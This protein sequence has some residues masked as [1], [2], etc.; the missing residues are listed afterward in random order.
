M[1][2]DR[3]DPWDF[4][5]WEPPP[6]G[7][8]DRDSWDEDDWEAHLARQD[9]LS[10][11]YQE[12]FETL[13]EHPE[14]DGIIAAEMQWN[15]PEDVVLGDIGCGECQ[16]E[17]PGEFPDELLDEDDDPAC[18]ACGCCELDG[19]PAFSRAHDYAVLLER[20]ILDRLPDADEDEDADQ[21][22]RAAG[23]AVEQVASGHSVGYERET[24]CGNIA[25][26]RRALASL[27]ECLDGL[28]QLRERG[29]LAPDE[30]ARFLAT[31]QDVRD[32]IAQRIE[33]LRSRVWW[34]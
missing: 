10:A 22:L 17:L 14:R 3:E 25:Y 18:D 11:K 4:E 19:I 33:D 6:Y 20:D 1:S 15:L 24:L 31:G 16:D 23:D 9:V 27:A 5:P 13:H 30:A 32:A 8:A 28:R 12:L 7:G 29:A 34:Q 26:C 21:V 2:R